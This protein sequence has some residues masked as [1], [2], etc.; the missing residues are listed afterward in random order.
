[1]NLGVHEYRE[2]PNLNKR[3]LD[4]LRQINVFALCLLRLFD[5]AQ[6]VGCPRDAR[7]GCPNPSHRPAFILEPG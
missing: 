4:N 2:L 5:L 1:M 7:I 3:P 6:I